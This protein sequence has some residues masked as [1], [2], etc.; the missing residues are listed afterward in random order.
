MQRKHVMLLG[1]I[2]VLIGLFIADYKGVNETIYGS[3][4]KFGKTSIGYDEKLIESNMS[5][6]TWI[7]LTDDIIVEQRIILDDQI[8]KYESIM[9]EFE[10]GNY[11]RINT[12][13]LILE[14]RQGNKV[15][16][17]SMQMEEVKENRNV[18]LVL[19]SENYSKGEMSISIYSPDATKTNFVGV[20]LSN[21]E[22]LF[23][24]VIVGM[25]EM[26]KNWAISLY[27]PSVFAVS[28]F[29]N[30][31]DEEKYQ[32]IA[33]SIMRKRDYGKGV[34]VF[35]K[36]SNSWMP[37][38]SKIV[39][40]QKIFITDEMLEE[41]YLLF[42]FSVG[43]YER[44]NKGKLI[45]EV[46]QNSKIQVYEINMNEI[47][48]DKDLRLVLNTENYFEG[49]MILRIYSPDATDD[50]CIA[51]SLVEKDLLFDNVCIDDMIVEK[52]WAIDI[53]M[54]TTDLIS[55]FILMTDNQ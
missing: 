17:F 54:P 50:N 42:Q 15:D 40:E 18:R 25:N 33:K 22:L 20:F 2:I 5:D 10:I 30:V 19:K 49:D 37:I 14:I 44:I 48:K 28:D 9:L 32:K 11:N 46:E 55:D 23:E 12:G 1:L 41:K 24:N 27:D 31:E 52:N 38:G 43:N 26:E 16:F 6:G 51:I 34:Y 13:E 21:R 45:I 53:Y 35:S 4:E 39:V 36:Q 8:M 3:I 7:A 47:E 29:S